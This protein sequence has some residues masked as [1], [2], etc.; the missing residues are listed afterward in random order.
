MCDSRIVARCGARVL[1]ALALFAV[2]GGSA[3]ADDFEYVFWDWADPGGTI[4]C[5]PFPGDL[6]CDGVVN[7]DDINPFVLT[8][9]DPDAYPEQFPDCDIMNADLNCDGV[10]N[11]D[12]INVWICLECGPGPWSSGD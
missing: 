9:C 12:D 6:N 7:F 4:T 8:L 5:G 10:I 1:V 3:R 2:V 11:F